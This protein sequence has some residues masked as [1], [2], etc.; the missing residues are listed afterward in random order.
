MQQKIISEGI[1]IDR[2][3]EKRILAICVTAHTFRG[4][5]ESV[6][7]GGGRPPMTV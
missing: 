5:V 1:G 2:I 3:N 7:R 4:L 6:S